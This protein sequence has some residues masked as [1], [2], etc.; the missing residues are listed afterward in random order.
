MERGGEHLKR[1]SG[2]ELGLVRGSGLVAVISGR[3]LDYASL[4]TG[5]MGD[6]IPSLPTIYFCTTESA[7]SQSSVSRHPSLRLSAGLRPRAR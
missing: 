1:A 7:S 5:A 4:T 3:V 6:F 2:S